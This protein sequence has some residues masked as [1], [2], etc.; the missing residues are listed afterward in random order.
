[1]TTSI[2]KSK[3]ELRETTLL[4]LENEEL[5]ERIKELK[6]QI[7]EYEKEM[8]QMQQDKESMAVLQKSNIPNQEDK[9]MH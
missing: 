5:R 3:Y 8:R 9:D 4:Q 6:K 1:M 2:M 7:Q